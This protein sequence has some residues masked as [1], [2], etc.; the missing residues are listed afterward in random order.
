M[1]ASLQ[2]RFLNSHFDQSYRLDKMLT[3][4]KKNTSRPKMDALLFRDER[5]WV[6]RSCRWATGH[7]ID[8]RDVAES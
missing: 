1:P 3:R 6:D 5:S 4:L 2:F 8:V 7:W